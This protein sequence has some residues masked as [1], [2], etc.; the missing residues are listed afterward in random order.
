M[1]LIEHYQRMVKEVCKEHDCLNRKQQE[2]LGTL[3]CEFETI[4]SKAYETVIEFLLNTEE[5]DLVTAFDLR[6]LE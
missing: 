4:G 5:I 1:E 3:L 2:T 6:D